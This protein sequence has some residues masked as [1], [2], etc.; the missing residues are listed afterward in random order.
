MKDSPQTIQCSSALSICL[1]AVV[2]LASCR[3]PQFSLSTSSKSLSS[4]L[5]N[6]LAPG[7]E[8]LIRFSAPRFKGTLLLH[9]QG[10]CSIKCC[11]SAFKLVTGDQLVTVGRQLVPVLSIRRHCVN[12]LTI[13]AFHRLGILDTQTDHS[14]GY[15]IDV[16]VDIII[17]CFIERIFQR[18]WPPDMD[19]S[20]SF[21]TLCRL[22]TTHP[23]SVGVRPFICRE[24][25]EK[26][27]DIGGI[28]FFFSKAECFWQAMWNGRQLQLYDFS[29][30]IS[31]VLKKR[32]TKLR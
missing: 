8:I 15:E 23:R 18:Q 14:D 12:R 20:V 6:C 27:K 19:V 9:P 5:P 31:I 17:I 1:T 2:T 24:T 7:C 16:I 11:G 10:P 3:G 26:Q 30:V 29:T 21:H 25:V 32:R 28:S 22:I 4:V 13:R